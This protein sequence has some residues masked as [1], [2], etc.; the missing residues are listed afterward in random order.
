MR[1]TQKQFSIGATNGNLPYLYNIQVSEDTPQNSGQD[2]FYRI[3]SFSDFMEYFDIVSEEHDKIEDLPKSLTLSCKALMKF[4]AYD[5]FY[6]AERTL[7][8]AK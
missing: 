1:I 8:I 2:N 5:G 6:P 7:E 3:Y 4:I